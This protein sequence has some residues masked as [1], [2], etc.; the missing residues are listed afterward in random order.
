MQSENGSRD[1][2]H[3]AVRHSPVDRRER[4]T[5]VRVACVL[6]EHWGEGVGTDLLN[7]LFDSLRAAGHQ[8]VWL[9]VIADN[10]VGRSFYD[11]HGFDVHEERTVEL[12]G[13]EVNDIVLVR[14]L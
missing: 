1:L 11:K 8:S 5:L 9:A 13:Q 4:A 14:D 3:P 10:D 6:P 12:A 7:R 2:P